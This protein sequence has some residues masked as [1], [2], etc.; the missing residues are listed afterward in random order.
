M[1]DFLRSLTLPIVGASLATTG[2]AKAQYYPVYSGYTGSAVYSTYGGGYCGGGYSGGYTTFGYTT[3][4]GY[5]A[6]GYVYGGCTPYGGSYL[7]G[8]YAGY[9]YYR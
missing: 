4:G 5:T 9:G 8:G 3:C 2:D 7:Y 6:G 1:N